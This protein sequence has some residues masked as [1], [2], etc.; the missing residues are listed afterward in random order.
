MPFP[1]R[2]QVSVPIHCATVKAVNNMEHR[3][4][5]EKI[6]HDGD[7]WLTLSV[8]ILDSSS[9]TPL[10]CVVALQGD[11]LT[12]TKGH[13]ICYLSLTVDVVGDNQSKRNIP[14]SRNSEPT[15]FIQRCR[16]S[17]YIPNGKASFRLC[18]FQPDVNYIISFNIHSV[19]DEEGL[20]CIGY[21]VEHYT[22]FISAVH[23]VERN[24]FRAPPLLKYEG[25]IAS[26]KFDKLMSLY[27]KLFYQGK[28]EESNMIMSRISSSD[29]VKPDIK[30]YMSM[31]KAT[32]K[33]FD[34]QTIPLLEE[35]FQ[36]SQSLDNQNGFL[37]QGLAMLCLSQTHSFQGRSE[38]ALD[39]LRYSRS[40]CFEVAPSHLTCC[41][42]LNHARMM[43][44]IHKGNMSP[45]IKRR[46]C[47]LFDRAIADSYYGVGWERLMIFQ[48]HLFKAE[49]CLNGVMDISL[50]SVPNY[51]P[52]EEDIS[53]AEQHLNAAPLE[54]ISEIH[55]YKVL[56]HTALSD[57]NRWK[58]NIE[59]AREH[60]EVAKQLCVEKGF[61]AKL[62]PSLDDRL[63]KLKP[64][65]I[66]E[67]LE[68]YKD[69][70]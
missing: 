31:S 3:D 32:E 7:E 40:I 65:I 64:D 61:F 30:L 36:R 46:I 20:E 8:S 9:G 21:T 1:Q 6:P 39:C 42:F 69:H 59:S 45:S 50:I 57:L 55:M 29:S 60:A 68:T 44:G 67:I 38:K 58:E 62:I 11:K 10:S 17:K 15:H 27:M 25:P 35:L 66:E 12:P 63:L 70:V 28:S 16:R 4:G 47:E 2:L 49:F 14:Q 24:A 33:P 18:F 41:V 51:I 52:T 19:Y 23:T 56:Y 48:S 22:G 53:L 26:K 34:A 5:P 37:L 54:L 43:I 13:I